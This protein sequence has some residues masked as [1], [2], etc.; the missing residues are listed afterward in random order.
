[1]VDDK[2]IKLLYLRLSFSDRINLNIYL[3]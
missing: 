2:F 1:M 3:Y